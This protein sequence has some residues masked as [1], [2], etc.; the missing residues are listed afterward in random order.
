MLWNNEQQRL[1]DLES[2]VLRAGETEY[3]PME[4]LDKEDFLSLIFLLVVNRPQPSWPSLSSK[5]RL[6]QLLV[7]GEAAKKPPK[8]R[9]KGPEKLIKITSDERKAG[10]A[11]N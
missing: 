1:K 3:G 2:G 7:K 10:P 6:K 8:V 4:L 11:H 5:G 9:L